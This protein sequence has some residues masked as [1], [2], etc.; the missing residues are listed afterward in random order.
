MSPKFVPTSLVRSS[1]I[2]EKEKVTKE[3][4]MSPKHI[5]LSDLGS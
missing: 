3:T 1:P 5:E 2:K 4:K